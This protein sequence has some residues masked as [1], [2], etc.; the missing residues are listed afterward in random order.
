MVDGREI[1]VT[2]SKVVSEGDKK[3]QQMRCNR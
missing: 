1:S 3:E 2:T